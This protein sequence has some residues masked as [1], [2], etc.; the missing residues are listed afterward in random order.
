MSKFLGIRK[1]SEYFGVSPQT[2]RRWERQGKLVATQRTP[3]NQRRYDVSS[4]HPRRRPAN[5]LEELPTVAYARVSS[6]DQKED[7]IRQQK[8]LKL[9]C[10]SHGWSFEILSD[11]GSGMNYSKRG[12]RKLIHK[13]VH[14]EIG[15]LV[16]THKDRL[17]KFGAELI[18]AVCFIGASLERLASKGT[19]G[20][21]RLVFSIIGMG[22]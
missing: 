11:L 9:F 3:G 18:F 10:S 16:L 15:R 4:L 5:V 13:I 8:M 1:A 20:H 17:L 12:L 21:K 22:F 7:L 14:Q 2:P 19:L 6:H